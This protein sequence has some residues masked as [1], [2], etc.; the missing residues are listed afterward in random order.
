MKLMI[1]A[2][3]F[4][5]TNVFADQVNPGPATQPTDMKEYTLNGYELSGSEYWVF[6]AGKEFKYPDDVIWDFT[7]AAPQAAQ[8]C[9]MQAYNKLNAFLSNPPANFVELRDLK[10]AT[11]RFYLWT[12]DYTRA[13]VEEEE[14]PAKFWHWNRG[15]KDYKQGYWKWES[16][17][18]HQG[19]CTIPN[20]QQIAEMILEIR[21]RLGL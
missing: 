5:A 12:N 7:G 15:D 9:A 16:S 1:A 8:E 18:S 2:V 6:E 13:A 19:V 10:G 3:L 20:D 21:S 4:L 11:P 14:R 17:V